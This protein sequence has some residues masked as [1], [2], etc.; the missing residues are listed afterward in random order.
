M[1]K[2]V[3]IIACSVGIM[4]S[5]PASA[6]GDSQPDNRSAGRTRKHVR[7]GNPVTPGSSAT[8]P[9]LPVQRQRGRPAWF[10]P[11]IPT[12][13]SLANANSTAAVSQYGRQHA[14]S[15]AATG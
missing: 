1:R 9:R 11:A 15:S 5:A 7:A 3:A 4:V 14:C 8:A 12:P 2:Y 13:P 10:T 6:V